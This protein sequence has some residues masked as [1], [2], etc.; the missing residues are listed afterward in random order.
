MFLYV[1]LFESPY[2]KTKCIKAEVTASDFKDAVKKIEGSEIKE[3]ELGRVIS[4]TQMN[5]LDLINER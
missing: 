2:D 4:A 5:K 3:I 1:F